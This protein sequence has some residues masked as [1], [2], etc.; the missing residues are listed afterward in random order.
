[1]VIKMKDTKLLQELT[2]IISANADFPSSSP[3]SV[4]ADNGAPSVSVAILDDGVLS[5][6]CYSTVGDDEDTVFQACSISKPIAGLGA[7][8]LIQAGKLNL[9]ASI[10]EYLPQSTLDILATPSTK[11]L[12]KHITIRH[13]MSHT[14]GL[15]VH[16]CP[17]YEPDRTVPEA[18]A[19][20]A[21]HSPSKIPHVRLGALPG[22]TFV[23]S[24]GGMT[25][26]QLC[27][28]AVGGRPFPELMKDSVLKPLGMHRSFLPLAAREWRDQPGCGPRRWT[29]SGAV[30]AVQLAIAADP[31]ESFLDSR[32]AKE[33]VTALPHVPTALTFFAPVKPGLGFGHT[34]DNWP[35]FTSYLWAYADVLTLHGIEQESHIPTDCAIAVMTNSAKGDRVYLQIVAAVCYLKGWPML[36]SVRGT[37]F[38][39]VPFSDPAAKVPQ[40]WKDWKG[41][42]ERGWKL[43]DDGQGQLLVRLGA[44][45]PVKALTAAMPEQVHLRRGGISLV[46][47]G[48][49]TLVRLSMLEG[50]QVLESNCRRGFGRFKRN[51]DADVRARTC[52]SKLMSTGFRSSFDSTVMVAVQLA[53]APSMSMGQQSTPV[54]HANIDQHAQAPAPAGGRGRRFR[55]RLASYK[56]AQHLLHA[57]LGFDQQSH[58]STRR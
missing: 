20:L 38:F 41:E 26:L 1:M 27:M 25:V 22:Q 13:L 42:W 33:M 43:E 52:P 35:G 47:Q 50:A 5:S 12:L 31:T 57:E 39:F 3:E 34:G 51:P 45:P 40:T 23:Y 48:L 16:G 9:D 58:V 2:S 11:H 37:D 21:G 18:A 10:T 49:N 53:P 15:T 36:A 19:S 56:H 30:R 24:G 32:W 46:L 17:G 8:K 55:H 6:H 29:C 7:M 28:E 4:L 54:Q 44:L 14:S